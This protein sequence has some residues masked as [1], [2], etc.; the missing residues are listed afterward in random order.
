MLTQQTTIG[1]GIVQDV[2]RY[3]VYT[4]NNQGSSTDLHILGPNNAE[5]LTV[6]NLRVRRGFGYVR[7]IVE[8]ARY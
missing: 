2:T 5:P 3:T 4:Y 7:F 1:I 8:K 6:P